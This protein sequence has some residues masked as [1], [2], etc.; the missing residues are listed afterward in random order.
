MSISLPNSTATSLRE[1]QAELARK[2]IVDATARVILRVGIHQFS[3]QEVA[4]EA[5]VSLRTLYRYYPSREE[6]VD[7]VGAEIEEALA[8]AGVPSTLEGPVTPE[9]LAT[10][11]VD[12]FLATE[13]RADLGRAWVI[14]KMVTGERSESSRGRDQLV[15]EVVDQLAPHLDQVEQDR[16]SGVLRFLAGSL[17]WKFMRDDLG[18][19]TEEI[20]RAVAW[21]ICTLLENV[22]AGGGPVDPNERG[23]NE[24]L[25]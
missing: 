22:G 7:G 4:D 12:A 5:G 23:S 21:A 8:E 2:L 19:S 16:V 9:S 25:D 18:M 20:G 11:V 1:Q 15:R 6:L 13:K 10:P 24:K 17:A 14:I 3:M